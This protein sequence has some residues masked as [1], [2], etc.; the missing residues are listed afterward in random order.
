MSDSEPQFRIKLHM[1]EYQWKKCLGYESILTTD[2]NE[3]TEICKWRA[4]H[5]CTT[6]YLYQKLELSTIIECYTQTIRQDWEDPNS[7]ICQWA[8]L[9][10]GQREVR[11]ADR[12]MREGMCVLL[13]V[14]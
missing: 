10:V 12:C 14:R 3:S 6:K 7:D 13:C 1:L 8:H 11:T 4:W 5:C 9:F 2:Q